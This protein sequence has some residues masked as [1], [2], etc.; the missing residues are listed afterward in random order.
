MSRCLWELLQGFRNP[1]CFTAR[2]C[3]CGNLKDFL[4]E[5]AK[6]CSNL[7]LVP[8]KFLGTALERG[9]TAPVEELSGPGVVRLVRSSGPGRVQLLFQES[10]AAAL[11]EGEGA[12]GGPHPCFTSPRPRVGSLAMGTYSADLGPSFGGG[13][14][15]C[16]LPLASCPGSGPA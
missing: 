2:T 14:T 4:A 8:V 1:R 11:A 7:G 16:F 12:H 3:S 10:W 6:S 9:P 15:F 13:R 5:P